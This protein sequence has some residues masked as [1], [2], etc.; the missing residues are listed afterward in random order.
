MTTE[1]FE[2]LYHQFWGL[3]YSQCL[4]SLGDVEEALDATMEVFARKWAAI[5]RYDP[6]LSSFKTWL[7]RNTHRL[8][9]DLLRKAAHRQTVPIDEVPSDAVADPSL[10]IE[11][12]VALNRLDPLDRQLALMRCV[13]EYTWS[14]LAEAA[15]LS[16]AQV[17]QRVADALARLRAWLG[18]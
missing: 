7:M 4:A 10:R 11:V 9:I 6:R 15:G 5:D 18:G 17:R 1:E 14:E 8:C 12:S 16:V 13:E 2:E 3:V